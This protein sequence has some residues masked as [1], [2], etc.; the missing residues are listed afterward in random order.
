[1]RKAGAE[2]ALA[3]DGRAAIEAVQAAENKKTGKDQPFDL[4]LMDMQMPLVDGYQATMRLRALGYRGPIIAITA[5]AMSQDRQKCL[6]AGCDDYL[7]KP[8]DHQ[9]LLETVARWLPEP[10]AAERPAALVV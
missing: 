8:I 1:L 5:H 7:S 10:T 3:A 4:I 2:V 9:R 6:D